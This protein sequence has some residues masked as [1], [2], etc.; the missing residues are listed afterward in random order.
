MDL[1]GDDN[2]MDD[3]GY[4]RH[5]R[6][7]SEEPNDNDDNDDRQPK[8]DADA[9]SDA[10]GEDGDGMAANGDEVDKGA[11]GDDTK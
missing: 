1:E 7:D 9:D 5:G 3:D 6:D 11:D 2:V 8:G 4:C 10:C